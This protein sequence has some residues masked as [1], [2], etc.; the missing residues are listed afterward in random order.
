[1]MRRTV[2]AILATIVLVAAVTSASAQ[3]WS[4]EQQEIWK[5]EELQWQMSKDKDLSWI[6]KM[7]PRT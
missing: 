2:S 5:F 4:P 1:M 6:D 3:S 7:V